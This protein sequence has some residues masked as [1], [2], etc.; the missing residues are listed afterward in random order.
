MLWMAQRRYRA[1]PTQNSA[2]RTLKERG[3]AVLVKT[4]ISHK[5]QAWAGLR[6]ASQQSVRASYTGLHIRSHLRGIP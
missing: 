5:Y 6:L 1:M 2:A 3:C 4:R